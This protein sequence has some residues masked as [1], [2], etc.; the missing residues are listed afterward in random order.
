MNVVTYAKKLPEK[1]STLQE[2]IDHR[3][4]QKEK[5]KS[6]VSFDKQLNI[7]QEAEYVDYIT[8]VIFH[9]QKGPAIA[10]SDALSMTGLRW[11]EHA[12]EEG[13][14]GLVA[15]VGKS[16]FGVLEGP[17]SKVIKFFEYSFLQNK[18]TMLSSVG[19]IHRNQVTANGTDESET[20]SNTPL[21]TGATCLFLENSHSSKDCMIIS[22]KKVERYSYETGVKLH[23]VEDNILITIM[24]RCKELISIGFQFAPRSCVNIARSGGSPCC[25]MSAS[26]FTAPND[27]AVEMSP[28]LVS[29]LCV[30]F[31]SFAD[32]TYSPDMYHE[33]S[34]RVMKVIQKY[35]GSILESFGEYMIVS[36][37][38]GN[39]QTTAALECAERL[40][41]RDPGN[42]SDLFNHVVISVHMGEVTFAN[43]AGCLCFGSGILEVQRLCEL[44]ETARRPLI[45]TPCVFDSCCTAKYEPYRVTINN[46][47]YFTLAAIGD[48]RLTNDACG[49]K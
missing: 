2:V 18:N 42:D 48:M 3:L 32:F 33:L 39:L 6:I 47:L 44:A 40:L 35:D 34:L 26:A 17:L 14:S 16:L 30:S 7:L 19:G 1:I 9:A 11:R 29:L 4:D 28:D 12:I 46:A 24:E 43:T 20:I 5:T 27:T 10:S 31:D 36:F 45:I 41:Y 13:V 37:P 8:R 38:R 22:M 25:T 15:V 23:Y 21:S 49:K